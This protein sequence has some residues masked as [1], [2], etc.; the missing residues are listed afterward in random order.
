[1]AKLSVNGLDALLLDLA[2]VAAI[3]DDVADEMLSAEAEIV[4]DAIRKEASQL[5]MYSGYNTSNNTRDTSPGNM[6]PGQTK[7]YSTGTLAKSVRVRKKMERKG[8]ERRKV[9][10]FSGS[11]K[12]GNTVTRNSEIAFL[13]EYGTRTINQRNFVWVAIEKS[14]GAAHKAMKK[15][16][17]EFLKSKNL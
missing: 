2:E 16:Y 15:I 13:N 11:R 5:G 9:I 8:A 17:D 3:P 1:M 4:A 12:R 10:Y 7:S 14:K 6:L